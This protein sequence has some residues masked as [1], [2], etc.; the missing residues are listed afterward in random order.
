[1]K[2]YRK[3]SSD[4]TRAILDVNTENEDSSSILIAP[5]SPQL[6]DRRGHNDEREFAPLIRPERLSMTHSEETYDDEVGLLASPPIV[7]EKRSKQC[8]WPTF[9]RSRTQ[10]SNTRN[11]TNKRKKCLFTC[12]LVTILPMI[13]FIVFCIVYFSEA[14]LPTNTIPLEQVK[15]LQDNTSSVR[16]LTFNMFMRPPGVK[17]NEND[18]KNERLDYILQNIL[19]SYDIIT[20]EEAFAYANRRIDK[21][22]LNAFHQGFYYHVAS[23]RH[24]PWEL[25]G[26]G[27]LLILSRY[28]IV[29]SNRM[30]FPRG[31]HADWL[32]YKGTLHALIEIAPNHT[33]H[34]YT[35]HTQASYDY[36]GAINFDDTKVRLS[37]FAAVH[38]FIEETAK[39]DTY[40]ILLMGDLN[41]DAAT[42]TASIDVPSY[43]SSLAYTMMM[44]VLRG[45]GTNLNLIE[46]KDI[47]KDDVVLSYASD[48]RLD[49]LTDMAY[50]T[51]GYHPVTFGDYKKLDN[52]TLVP[53]ET[54]LTSHSQLKTVQSIDRL[55]WSN[56][57]K[58]NTMSLSNV[59]VEHFFV[60]ND[61]AYPFTQISDHYGLSAILYL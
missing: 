21:F 9:F 20:I 22:L 41:V 46:K 24:Y 57:D 45:K 29:K 4:S 47:P 7:P 16:L 61:T 31:V 15:L 23:P 58:N 39:S 42:H 49:N 17:N 56:T 51:F 8:P 27:G 36:A 11:V 6:K 35:T 55:L 25:A 54:V 34:V 33:I 13:S 10:N 5:R 52:G 3:Q 37:Q 26:D 43:N 14:R 32:S 2:S 12:C 30:E 59:T 60:I 1:M 19:P 48:W 40:P 18:Y 50:K 53:A 44:D 38:Q 28:P